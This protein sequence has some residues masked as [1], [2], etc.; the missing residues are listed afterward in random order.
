MSSFNE[1]SGPKSGGGTPPPSRRD[2]LSTRRTL[3]LFA[4]GLVV[5]GLGGLVAVTFGSDDDSAGTQQPTSATTTIVKGAVL[6]TEMGPGLDEN[7][8]PYLKA[9]SK[10]LVK[11]KGDR[12]AVVSFKRYLTEPEARAVSGGSTITALLAALPGG[13]PSV[14]KGSVDDWLSEQFAASREERDQIRQLLPTVD[15]PQFQAD[16]QARI[17]ELNNIIGAVDPD[18]PLVFGLVVRAPAESLQTLAKAS[19][20]RVVDV[21][22]AAAATANAVFRGVRPEEVTTA[23]DPPARPA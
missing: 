23:N 17:D 1:T 4:V 14:V 6:V 19:D 21:G 10:D 5:I 20:V 7:L 3:M 8:A 16:Y 11:A 12:V 2:D 22:P 9:R 15:D 13:S 18:Q